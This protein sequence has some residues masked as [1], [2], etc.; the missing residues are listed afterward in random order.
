M[1]VNRPAAARVCVRSTDQSRTTC[2]P[3]CRGSCRRECQMLHRNAVKSI[4]C[5]WLQ[6]ADEARCVA[7]A[8]L[9]EHHYNNTSKD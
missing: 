2:P 4:R 7:S 1:H 9:A 3:D 8:K 5:P 6:A